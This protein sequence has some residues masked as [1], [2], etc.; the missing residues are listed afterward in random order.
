MWKASI[1]TE[2]A[3]FIGADGFALCHNSPCCGATYR[4]GW[5]AL[6][7]DR[8]KCPQCS[9]VLYGPKPV[10]APRKRTAQKCAA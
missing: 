3:H 4:T 2:R 6:N 1:F 10:S 8:R 5:V 9:N 7:D